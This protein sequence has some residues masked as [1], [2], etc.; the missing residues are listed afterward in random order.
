MKNRTQES[1]NLAKHEAVI[2]ALGGPL[3]NYNKHQTSLLFLFLSH[4]QTCLKGCPAPSTFRNPYYVGNL[5]V[6][7]QS[8]CGIINLDIKFQAR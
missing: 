8:L 2:L 7:S 6:P 5:F 1:A 4:F 3:P